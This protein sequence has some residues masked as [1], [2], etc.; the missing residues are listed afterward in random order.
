MVGSYA[1]FF[2]LNGVVVILQY[3]SNTTGGSLTFIGSCV[4]FL[5]FFLVQFISLE[6]YVKAF[7]NVGI[8]SLIFCCFSGFIFFSFD[9]ISFAYDLE[10]FKISRYIIAI[11]GS[12][13]I[14]FSSLYETKR[15]KEIIVLLYIICGVWAITDQQ[16]KLT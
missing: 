12:G 6:R 15:I 3:V 8:F 5:G 9:S 11:F 7:Y 4:F 16:A 1:S 2:I 10:V 14:L 13:V